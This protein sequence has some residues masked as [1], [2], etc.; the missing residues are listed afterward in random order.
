M[1]RFRVFGHRFLYE[2]PRKS[3]REEGY[4]LEAIR[5]LA[6]L[7][8]LYGLFVAFSYGLCGF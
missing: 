3:S 1:R 2:R 5:F 8:G 7:A 6:V 4:I